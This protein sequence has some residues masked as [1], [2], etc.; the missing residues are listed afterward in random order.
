MNRIILLLAVIISFPAVSQREVKTYYDPQRK[1]VQEVYYVAREDNEKLIGK[2]ERYYPDGKLALAGSFDD[3][4]K[5]G[6]FTEYHETGAPSRKMVYVNG[7][8]HGPVEVFDE[9]GKKIQKAY[10]QNDLLVDSVQSFYDNGVM[11]TE[12]VFK[13]GKPEVLNRWLARI[14]FQLLLLRRCW[15]DLH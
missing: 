2:Y 6:Q 7:M 9:N 14:S 11:K 4:K 10:Y 3:G 12:T 13:K 1:Q 5:S 8:R 15:S